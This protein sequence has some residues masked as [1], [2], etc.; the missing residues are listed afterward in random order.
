MFGLPPLSTRS[1]SL[2]AHPLGMRTAG[3]V[4][5]AM[6]FATLG[7][8]QEKLSAPA[9]PPQEN[10]PAEFVGSTTCQ[11]CHEDIFNGFQ[12]NPH[13][14]VEKDKKRG[15]ENNACESCHGPGSKHAESMAAGDIRNPAKLKPAETDKTCLTCHLN[16]ATHVGRINS[17]HAKNQV[18]CAACHSIHKNGPNGLVARKPADQGMRPH[19]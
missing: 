13:Q 4:G 9:T 15:F 11:G 1:L 17:S 3:L 16:Q 18:S 7:G 14:A 6:L 19:A 8:A 10:K 12:K 5:A 2:R